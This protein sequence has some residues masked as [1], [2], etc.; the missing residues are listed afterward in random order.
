MLTASVSAHCRTTVLEIVVF[1]V[2]TSLA[3]LPRLSS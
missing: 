1:E 2:V 3:L